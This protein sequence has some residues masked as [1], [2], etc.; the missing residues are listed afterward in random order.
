MGVDHQQMLQ[1]FSIPCKLGDA[2]LRYM[3]AV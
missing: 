1:G 2:G 3:R